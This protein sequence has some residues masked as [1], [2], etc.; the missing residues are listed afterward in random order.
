MFV[1]LKPPFNKVKEKA[2]KIAKIIKQIT[3]EEMAKEISLNLAQ[4][5]IDIKLDKEELKVREI[6][7]SDI[8]EILVKQLKGVKIEKK[9]SSFSISPNLRDIKKLYKLKEKVKEIVISGVK[10]VTEILPVMRNGEW[11]VQTFGSN[12]KGVFQVEEVDENR[13]TSNNIYEV[14][15]VLGIEA[16]RQTVI[17]ELLA[18]LDE[19]GMPVDVRH[20][21]LVADLMCCTGELRGITRHGITSQKTSVLARASFEIP[22]KHLIDASAVGE[23]DALSSVVENI[24]INQPIPVGTGLPDLIV[25]MKR[26]SI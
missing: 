12:L 2:E 18:V 1:Y 14:A 19:Q 6:K 20:L 8:E 13:T 15:S 16:A 10:D 24:M 21:L 23:T 11:V 5:S 9:E 17:N 22:L 3:L 7:P 4:F 26:E 25:H